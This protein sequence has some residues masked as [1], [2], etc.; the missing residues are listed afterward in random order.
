MARPADAARDAPTRVAVVEGASADPLVSEAT[1][2][3]RA[4]LAEAG[5]D[6]AVVPGSADRSPREQVE[7]AGLDPPPVATLAL[8]RSGTAAAADVWVADRITGKTLVR[9]VDVQDVRGDRAARVL[10]VRT[11]EL[12]RASLLEA[13]DEAAPGEPSTPAAPPPRVPVDVVRWMEAPRASRPFVRA[14]VGAGMLVGFPGSPPAFAPVARFGWGTESAAVRVS[15]VAPAIG[16]EVS[17]PGGSATLRQELALLEFTGGFPARGPWAVVGSAGAGVSHVFAD[18]SAEAP[19]VAH[20]GESFTGA[21]AFG[22][23]GLLRFGERVGLLADL[24]A[25]L[26]AP[27]VSVLV[28]DASRDARRPMELVTFGLWGAF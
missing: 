8:F 24:E 7:A 6:V 20:R 13:T 2:R 22:V 5:F 17:A 25:V 23:G 26:L 15:V 11:V 9:H 14:E 12:L 27:R 10:A 4:E 21:F 3:V 28:A 19:L 16:A 18:G 1:T